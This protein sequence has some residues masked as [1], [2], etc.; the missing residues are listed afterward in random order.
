MKRIVRNVIQ[1]RLGG[2]V[3]RCHNIPHHGG[4]SVAAHS[5][6]VAMLLMA[7]WPEDKELLLYALAHDVAEGWV[8]DVP[9]P[10]CRYVPGVRDQLGK[11]EEILLRMCGLDDAYSNLEQEDIDKIKACDRLEFV[12]WAMEQV[13][14]GNNYVMEALHEMDRVL[15]VE[16]PLP[17]RAMAFYKELRA[18]FFGGPE[19]LP[20]Q[21]GV[22]RDAVKLYEARK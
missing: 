9:A 8:G 2:K 11:V 20:K 10:T 5:W 4:Y 7:L 6:G 21:A 3:E 22:V 14:M 16:S 1:Q 13:Q 17:E 19:F 15:T 18:T 12:L